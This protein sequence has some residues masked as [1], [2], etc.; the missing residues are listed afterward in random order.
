[1]PPTALYV[2]EAVWTPADLCWLGD[3]LV[4]GEGFEPSASRSRN[5]GGLVHRELF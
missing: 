1:M 3:K 2:H 4:G 5:L